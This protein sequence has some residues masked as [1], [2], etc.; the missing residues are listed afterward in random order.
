METFETFVLTKERREGFL[1]L[2]L[3]RH[4]DVDDLA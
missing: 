2:D 4:R 1:S 3:G